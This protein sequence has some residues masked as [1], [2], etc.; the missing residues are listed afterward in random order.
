MTSRSQVSLHANDTT[1]TLSLFQRQIKLYLGLPSSCKGV[2][3]PWVVMP[4]TPLKDN[5]RFEGTY[6]LHLQGRSQARN[7]H[8]THGKWR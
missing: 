8:E 3:N 7:Q 2:T 1:V 5:G 6:R 4:C